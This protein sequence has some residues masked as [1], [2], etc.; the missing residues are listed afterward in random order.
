M[1]AQAR[2]RGRVYA[3][4]HVALLIKHTTRMR[5]IV[6]PFVASLDPPFFSILSQ[7]RYDFRKQVIEHKICVLIF[8]TTFV[9]EHSRF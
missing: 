9:F 1:R 2:A 6:T 3:C 5:H 4:V 8:A 7:K